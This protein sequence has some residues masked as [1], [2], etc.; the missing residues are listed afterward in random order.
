M[1][2]L[3]IRTVFWASLDVPGSGSKLPSDLIFVWYVR[4]PGFLLRLKFHYH[5]PYSS[6][7]MNFFLKFLLFKFHIFTA[8]WNLHTFLLVIIVGPNGGLR[9]LRLLKFSPLIH[10]T[11]SLNISKF[12]GCGFYIFVKIL[13][14]FS[15]SHYCD[16][17]I[18]WLYLLNYFN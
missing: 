4:R 13:K 6:W 3:S 8:L 12:R 10:Y 11:T 15:I 18:M 5:W 14:L 7:V 1:V 17:S 16:N 9:P 2:S